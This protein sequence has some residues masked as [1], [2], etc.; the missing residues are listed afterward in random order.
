MDEYSFYQEHHYSSY[1]ER[2]KEVYERHQK[3]E[4]Y[5]D[6][7]KDLGITPNRVRQIALRWEEELP[8]IE[9]RLTK[10]EPDAGNV[11]AQK[12]NL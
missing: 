3:G 9:A 6:I 5:K 7:A 11:T 2:H 4:T 8:R 12:G 10:R 1:L